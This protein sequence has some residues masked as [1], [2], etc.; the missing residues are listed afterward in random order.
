MG[1]KK[2]W[3]L[4]KKFKTLQN[5]MIAFFSILV[6]SAIVILVLFSLTY[7]RQAIF[8]NSVEY[9][10]QIVK[11]VN[12]DID[13]YIEYMKNISSVVASSEDVPFYLFERGEKAKEQQ[14]AKER[15]LTQFTTIMEGR[16][17]ISNI[18]VLSNK[19]KYIL[20]QGESK[21]NPYVNARIQD[22]YR[23]ALSSSNGVSLSS[24]HVQNVIQDSYQ[25]VITLS[26]ALLNS[27]S[28]E[29]EGVFF[30]DLNYS[31]ISKLCDNSEL[32]KR[33]YIYILDERGNIV[34]HPKQQLLYGGLIQEKTEEIMECPKSSFMTYEGEESKL[35]TISRSKQS[36][37]TVVGVVYT[38]ELLHV[39]K[40]TKILYI[41][42]T[43]TLL[44]VVIVF[45]RIIAGRI[46]KPIQKLRDLM[47]RVQEGKFEKVPEEVFEMNEIESLN[48]SFNVMVEK[49]DTLME[50][51]V[52]EQKQ[53]RKSELQAL[54]AQINPHFLYNTLDSIIW[55]AESKKSEEVVRMTA[56]LAR[57]FRQNIS[58][59]NEWTTIS[60]EIEYVKSYLTIQKMRYKDKLDYEILVDDEVKGYSIIKLVLQPIVENAIY[61]GLKYKE[62][63]GNL[64]IRGYIQEKR[65]YLEVYDNGVGMDKEIVEHIFDERKTN[66]QR[67]GVGVWNVQK[68]LR[69]Y[70]GE[71]YGIFFESEKG[72]GTKAT[73]QIPLNSG[74]QDEQES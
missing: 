35:Y 56:A 61:H 21:F 67:N 51:N 28:G 74:G 46:T 18:G 71:D 72:I 64:L 58:N 12:Y 41:G 47:S 1:K 13:S 7:T 70:Y 9:T 45:S 23:N 4:A 33:G 54:Q 14:E 60:Q 69:L 22:W 15:I 48:K 11:Q 59:E 57:L 32:G 42:I 30:I 27:R 31:A 50:Q 38:E 40:Q 16:D 44:F 34:Y 29:K 43:F 37:W 55:M 53:K 8:E 3:N 66:Y 39:D 25:W 73:I 63:K 17:D 26:R 10:S 2:K 68:R 49:I 5:I 6:V 36:G 24:P 20:N 19:S 65:I 62:G 52:Y